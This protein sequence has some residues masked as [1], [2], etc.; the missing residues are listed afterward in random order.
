MR[1]Y[2]SWCYRH[3]IRPVLF[4]QD[5]ETIH[6]RILGG[7]N[8]A[9]KIPL[10]PGV[11]SAFYQSQELPV[12]A[13]GLRFPNPIGLAAGMDKQAAAVPIW[14]KLGFGFCELGGVTRHPQPGNPQ[15]R[16]FRCVPDQALINRMGFNN[17]GADALADRLAAWKKSGN[18]PKHPV[19]MNLGK[20]KVTPLNEAA[21]DYAYS[22]KVLWPFVDF[23]VVN[24]SSP[25]TPGLRQLQDRGALDEILAA[26]AETNLSRSRELAMPLKPVLVKVSPDL[27]F[28]A[29]DELLQVV[30]DRKLSGIVATNTTI[31]RPKSENSIQN[32]VYQQEGGLSGKPLK[33]RST[34]VI[35]H[36]RKH[37]SGN[38]P[39]I[40]VGGIMGAQDA[41]DKISAGACL[42]QTYTGFVYEGPGLIHNLVDGLR[43]RL[44]ARGLTS[45]TQAVGCGN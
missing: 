24:V 9:S 29:L 12:E 17:P 11:L 42:L 13:F 39:I 5:S 20:S 28:E 26:L 22:F 23:F 16:M 7:L 25:N 10:L 27:T 41:W 30:L 8:F 34:E 43:K 37:T 45:L 32:E 1:K 4:R 18:W 6:N 2:M 40:G 33:E 15:P 36:I 35:R 21:L 14:E 38:L 3:L 44:A 19:A 31:S